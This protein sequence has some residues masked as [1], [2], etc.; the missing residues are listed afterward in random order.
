MFSFFILLKS[1]NFLFCEIPTHSL[2]DGV[3]ESVHNDDTLRKKVL[4]FFSLRNS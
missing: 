4:Y 2:L 1:F 3:L